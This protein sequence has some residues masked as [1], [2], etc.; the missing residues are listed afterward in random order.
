MG[1]KLSTLYVILLYNRLLYKRFLLY[2]SVLFAVPSKDVQQIPLVRSAIM[3]NE[4]HPLT[5]GTKQNQILYLER[6][7]QAGS[8]VIC[9]FIQEQHLG[10]LR[11]C[12]DIS[13]EHKCRFKKVA[14]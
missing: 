1:F 12:D 4:T 7:V 8:A 5:F 13:Y 6:T 10:Y 2:L 9:Y 11:Q 14:A 3:S